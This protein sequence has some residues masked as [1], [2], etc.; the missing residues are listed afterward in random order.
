MVVSLPLFV[1]GPCLN[2][3]HLPSRGEE[4]LLVVG[5]YVDVGCFILLAVLLLLG[6]VVVHSR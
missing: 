6:A 4:E 2:A 3:V 5:C 1:G